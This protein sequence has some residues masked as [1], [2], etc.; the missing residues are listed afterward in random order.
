MPSEPHILALETSHRQGSVALCRGETLLAA[1]QLDAS[2]RTAQ[3]LLPAIDSL[4][5]QAGWSPA[6]L[7][8]IAVSQGPGSF[9]GLRIGVTT[10]KTLAY[11]SGAGIV[12]LNTLEVIAAQLLLI[13][14]TA[15]PSR[16]LDVVLDAQRQQLFTARYRRL[17]DHL[18]EESAT[19]IVDRRAW[20]SE[21]QQ[22]DCQLAG[23][24][25]IASAGEPLAALE[26]TIIQQPPQAAAVAWLAAR[27]LA[28][29]DNWSGQ[30]TFWA[31]AGD[32][33]AAMALVP[34]YFRRSAAEE[35]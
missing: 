12:G 8:L 9:T 29:P 4:L 15:D 16:P 19:S 11:A 32:S 17:D 18:V 27:R 5:Q 30:S 1:R 20:L 35:K 24:L 28:Q 26:A 6:E 2:Q 10:A 23:L 3:S 25:A 7:D 14:E 21:R 34:Q 33:D 13:E 22:Q 31:A